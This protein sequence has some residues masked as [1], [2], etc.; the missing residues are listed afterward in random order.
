MLAWNVRGYPTPTPQGNPRMFKINFCVRKYI[1]NTFH[2]VVCVCVWCE[3]HA[4]ECAD[5]WVCN[6]CE[7]YNRMLGALLLSAMLF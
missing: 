2:T 7:D 4:Y 3:L 6:T 5:A 1:Q